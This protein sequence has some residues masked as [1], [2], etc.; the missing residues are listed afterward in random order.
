MAVYFHLKIIFIP[1][2]IKNKITVSTTKA[3]QNKAT[4]IQKGYSVVFQPGTREVKKSTFVA[5][6]ISKIAI[7]ISK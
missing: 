5:T 3:I 7:R 1:F 6:T 2:M 4:I